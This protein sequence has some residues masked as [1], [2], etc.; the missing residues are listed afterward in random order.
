M[1]LRRIRL[2]TLNP[3]WVMIELRAAGL[4][5]EMAQKTADLEHKGREDA[6][7]ALRVSRLS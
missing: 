5:L 7:I 6:G 3:R 4:V 2:F 1:S